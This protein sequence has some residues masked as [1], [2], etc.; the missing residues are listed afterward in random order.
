MSGHPDSPSTSTLAA[1]SQLHSKRTYRQIYFH[2]LPYERAIE[3]AHAR[4]LLEW[5]NFEVPEWKTTA[6]T[7]E[8]TWEAIVGDGTPE[9]RGYF[10]EYPVLS[11]HIK[12]YIAADGRPTLEYS[13]AIPLEE[14]FPQHPNGGPFLYAGRFDMLGQKPDGTPIARDEKST[15]RSAGAKWARQWQLRGQ[16]I[17]YVWALQQCG[18]PAT[19]VCV[20]GIHILKTS[21]R[22][23]EHVQSYSNDLVSR[24]YKQLK[25]DVW[26]MQQMYE[27]GYWDFNLAEACTNYGNCIFMDSCTSHQPEVWLRN[28]EIRRW[29]PLNATPSPSASPHSQ[30]QSNDHRPT[31]SLHHHHAHV[32]PGDILDP[33]HTLGVLTMAFGPANV[34]RHNP[35]IRTDRHMNMWL[36]LVNNAIRRGRPNRRRSTKP[37]APSTWIWFAVA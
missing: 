12:P 29:N 10:Q 2:K 22:H 1:A 33:P 4:F 11:D 7:M 19:E 21:I 8:R 18:I 6:K 14:G 25:R 36:N 13:F 3:I 32:H 16:F 35:L 9:G 17:G 23:S 31:P 26:R 24:W 30:G 27:D 28:M 20:R 5:G 37:T 15:G 34:M